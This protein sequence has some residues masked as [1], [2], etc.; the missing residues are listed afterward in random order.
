MCVRLCSVAVVF[1]NMVCVVVV[2]DLVVL[3]AATAIG[4]AVVAGGQITQFT[5][6]TGAFDLTAPS[7]ADIQLSGIQFEVSCGYKW[8]KVN[9]P[10]ASDH[11][12]LTAEP[13]DV[14]FS[15]ALDFAVN[16]GT[17]SVSESGTTTSIGDFTIHFDGKVSRRCWLGRAS[18]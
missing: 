4:V 9:S 12:T 17:A 7:T 2:A 8:R 1:A 18:E 15:T 3:I 13:S 5:K 16:N 10:H 11:G 14:V 6:P